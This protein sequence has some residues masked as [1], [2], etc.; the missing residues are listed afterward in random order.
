MFSGRDTGRDASGAVVLPAL[1]ARHS[2]N[3]S[4]RRSDVRTVVLHDTEGAY[5]GAVSWLCNP[6]ARAS[7]HVVLR[8]D[9][10]EATQ[11]VPYDMKAWACMGYNGQ[12]INVEMAGL[13]SKGYGDEELR[14]A[15]RVVAF[16]LHKYSLPASHVK[17]DLS[18]RLGRG[19]SL[20][21][22]LGPI[23]GGHHDPGFSPA[24]AWWFGR[25][26]AQE[27]ARGGFRRAWGVDGV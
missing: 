8:E 14:V 12:S 2:P 4:P 22:D 24:K 3:Q 5:E 17:P 7:A 16:F 13:A 15:A 26:V 11:L 18:G 10:L 9:G 20:H 21:Q 19:W 6:A 27:L 23:G 25:L 1:Y